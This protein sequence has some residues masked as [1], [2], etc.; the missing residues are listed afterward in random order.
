MMAATTTIAAPIPAARSMLANGK[1]GPGELS[2]NGPAFWTVP[3][4][5]MTTVTFAVPG[6]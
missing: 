4:W 2:V 1:D 6:L 3:D 5:G